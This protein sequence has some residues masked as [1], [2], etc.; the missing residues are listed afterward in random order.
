VCCVMIGIVAAACCSSSLS[1]VASCLCILDAQCA[2]REQHTHQEG[3]HELL[4]IDA[5]AGECSDTR[6]YFATCT[7][8]SDARSAL[9]DVD[10]LCAPI[11]VNE[12]I[13]LCALSRCLLHAVT[14]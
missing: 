8:W 4:P 6:A 13:N 10:T 3:E 7:T 11:S 1:I 5:Q 2:D 9:I 14:T 12:L